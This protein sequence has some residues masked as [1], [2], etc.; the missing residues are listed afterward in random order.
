[1]KILL[2]GGYVHTPADPHATALCIED[3]AIVWTGDDDAS[4]HFEDGADRIV[5]LDGRLVTPAFVDAH[6]HLAQTGLAAAGA[7][8]SGTADL[9]EALDVL[10]AHGRTTSDA[11]VLGYGWDETRWPEQRPFTREEVDRALGGRP[12]YLARVDEHSAVVSTAFLDACPDV[13]HAD[14]YDVTGRVERDAHHAVRE[15]LFRLLPPSAREDAILRALRIAAA[16]GIGMVHELG[17]PHICPP[18]DLLVARNL[19]AAGG[20]PEVVAY[21]G[22][23]DAVDLAR[24]LGAVGLAGDLCMDGSIGSRTSALHAPY[25]DHPHDPG[26]DGHLYLDAEQ[27]AA[28]VVTCT[29][30]GLQAGFHVIGDRAV[31][32]VTRGFAAAAETLGESAVVRGRHRLEH[33]EMVAPEQMQTL[34]RLGITASQQP[35]FDAYWGGEKGMY[36]QRLGADRALA[37][38]AFATLNRAGVALAFGSDTPVTPFG[39]WAGVRAAAWHHTESERVTVR[40]AFNAHTRG[41]WRAAARDEGGVIAI[42]A[43]ASVA[44]FDVPGDLVVQTPDARVAAWSTDPRAGVPHLP[45]LHPDLDLPRCVMTLVH[46][47]VAHESEGE[48]S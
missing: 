38:N 1:M 39:P 13:V 19:T 26:H 14:G 31:D 21:W 16:E 10:A 7:D 9:H 18:E 22:E 33:L 43:P 12:A 25:A 42:G 4:V 32:A 34:G 8:F 15:G 2:R 41:G 47:A 6:A 29:Q 35:A 40:A 36:A 30:A 3:G 20:L 44:V 24:E 28:H 23:L 37:M 45:D 11:V 27:V 46:G 17:A 5:E 48:L